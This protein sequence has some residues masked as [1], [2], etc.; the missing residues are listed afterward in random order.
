VSVGGSNRGGATQRDV[1][2]PAANAGVTSAAG[3]STGAVSNGAAHP[4][5]PVEGPVGAGGPFIS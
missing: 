5:V 1:Q 2:E 4:P 3:A